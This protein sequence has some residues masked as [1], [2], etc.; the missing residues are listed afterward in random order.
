MAEKPSHPAADEADAAGEPD[1]FQSV[2]G[3]QAG[4]QV[5][6]PGSLWLCKRPAQNEIG[7]GQLQI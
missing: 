3:A 7:G 6:G 1:S 4:V 2:L 5:G